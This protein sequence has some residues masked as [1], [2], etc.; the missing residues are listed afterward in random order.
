MILRTRTIAALAQITVLEAVRNRL[1]WLAA[2]VIVT[3][4]GLAQFLN[5]VAIA[6]SREIQSAM[7]A[8][9][10]RVAAVFIAAAFV[11]TSMVREWN[12]K[13]TEL[14]LSLPAPR[15][16]YFFGKFAGYAALALILAPLMAL[17]LVLVSKH[18]G[19]A[20]WTLSLFCEL[21]IVTAVSMF[22]VLSLTQ[23]VPAFV[24]VAGFYMLSRS[25]GAIQIIA[26][27]PLQDPTLADRMENV[28]VDL[29]AFVL[30]GLDRMTQTSWLTELG[31]IGPGTIGTVLAQTAIYVALICSASLFDLYRKN[32]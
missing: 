7:L 2:I 19:L 12:D 23:V 31:P 1:A 30:P 21:L 8:A 24:A 13:V 17:P 27:A 29:I 16:A 9:L 6:E 28:I 22:C 20:L 10:L 11:I 4:F 3:A 32:L 18:G 14:L 5:Q 25:M 15:S 26:G